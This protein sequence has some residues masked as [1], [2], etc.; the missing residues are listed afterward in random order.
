MKQPCPYCGEKITVGCEQ[1]EH[2][3][4]SLGGKGDKPNESGGPT[5][6]DYWQSKRIPAWLMIV[7]VLILL[8][9]LVAMFI[10]R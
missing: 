10:F 9:G 4:K 6:L 1:C 5:D 2:C 8:F 3:G 7:V